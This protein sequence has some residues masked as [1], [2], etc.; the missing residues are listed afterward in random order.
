MIKIDGCCVVL[1]PV[2]IYFY[3]MRTIYKFALPCRPIQKK[4]SCHYFLINYQYRNTRPSHFCSF[5]FHPMHMSCIG[6]RDGGI[7]FHS[8]LYYVRTPLLNN[9]IFNNIHVRYNIIEYI[10]I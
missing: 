7:A 4:I 3:F 10:A 2:P 5:L 9:N 6:S 8:I 1:Y